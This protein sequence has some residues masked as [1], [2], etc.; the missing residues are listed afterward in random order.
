LDKQWF[1]NLGSLEFLALSDNKLVSIETDV[2]SGLSSLKNLSLHHNQISYIQDGAFSQLPNLEILWLYDNRIVGISDGVFSGATT[3][4]VVSLHNNQL[5]NISSKAFLSLKNAEQIYLDGNLLTSLDSSLFVSQQKLRMLELQD[6]KFTSVDMELLK[7]LVSLT[8]FNLSGN[9]LVCDCALWDVWLWWS[10][11]DLNPLATCQLPQANKAVAVR[12]QLEK[13][14]CNPDK[15]AEVIPTAPNTQT[16]AENIC[17]VRTLAI[18]CLIFLIIICGMIIGLFV[19]L[20]FY[21]SRRHVQ[22]TLL[23]MDSEAI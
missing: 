23:P 14:T 1:K 12:E 6:N 5:Q 18:W 9:P 17:E 20:R 10:A 15:T 19:Y 8:A 21:I 16:Q 3:I 2:F 11:H 7:P 22:Q 13:L 4:R